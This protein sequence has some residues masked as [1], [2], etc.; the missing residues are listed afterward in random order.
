MERCGPRDFCSNEG[1]W[2]TYAEDDVF[3]LPRCSVFR[4]SCRRQACSE[5]IAQRTLKGSL[6]GKFRFLAQTDFICSV[7]GAVKDELALFFLY[8]DSSGSF[9]IMVAGNGRM[10]LRTWKGKQY[11][12][13]TSLIILPEEAQTIPAPGSKFSLSVELASIE[14]LV[15]QRSQ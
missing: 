11:V 1:L 15:T 4:E 2:R 13:P 10:P 7:T 3:L 6:S 12:T 9:N 8:R 5:A 14:K